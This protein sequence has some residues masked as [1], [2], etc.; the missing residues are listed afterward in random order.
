MLGV[1]PAVKD[2]GGLSE[3]LTRDRQAEDCVCLEG[4]MCDH[5]GGLLMVREIIKFGGDVTKF[6]PK[7]YEI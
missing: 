4:R 7:G 1:R 3:H 2:F 6:L 5:T